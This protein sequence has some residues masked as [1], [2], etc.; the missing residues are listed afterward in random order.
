MQ[1][2]HPGLPKLSRA[3]E[4]G[5][6]FRGCDQFVL[7]AREIVSF[8]H[9]GDLILRENRKRNSRSLHYAALRSG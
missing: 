4:L 5:G 1:W 2:C 6:L 8:I 9:S 3:P 7:A